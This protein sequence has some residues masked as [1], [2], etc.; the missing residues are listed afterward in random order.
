MTNKKK[1]MK[2]QKYHT[3]GTVPKYNR[4]TVEKEER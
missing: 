1:K 3:S 4:Q 2:S